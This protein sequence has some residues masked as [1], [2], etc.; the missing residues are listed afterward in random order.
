MLVWL[1]RLSKIG[2]ELYCNIQKSSQLNVAIIPKIHQPKVSILIQDGEL[3]IQVS[4]DSY[5]RWVSDIRMACY[6]AVS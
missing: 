2:C 6:K 3:D 5:S 4:F 1:T